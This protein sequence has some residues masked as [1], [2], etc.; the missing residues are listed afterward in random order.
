M[1]R[2]RLWLSSPSPLTFLLLATTFVLVS[3]GAAQEK[4]H[5]ALAQARAKARSENQRVLLLITGGN[6]VV[7][8]GLVKALGNYRSLGKL[9]KYEYQLA[10][11]PAASIAAKALR[12]QLKL[13][14]QA[15][16]VLAALD[17]DDKVV[18]TLN[19]GEMLGSAGIVVKSV[20]T[21][22]EAHA[23]APLDARKVLAEGLA[24]A[25]ASKRHVLLYLSAPW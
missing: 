5:D 22:L 6:T 3:T 4:S 13:E 10:A 19:A 17:T 15:L 2:L 8:D 20:R 11:L 24:S 14:D 12:T 7:D 25:T 18:G 16:P 1:K 9:L 21:F 23:C